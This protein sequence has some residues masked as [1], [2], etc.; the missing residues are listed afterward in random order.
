MF[1]IIMITCYNNMCVLQTVR[2]G[3]LPI[4]RGP[5]AGDRVQRTRLQ[6]IRFAGRRHVC[7]QTRRVHFPAHTGHRCRC[8]AEQASD[9]GSEDGQKKIEIV[10]DDRGSVTT[11]FNTSIILRYILHSA[12][13]IPAGRRGFQ[14]S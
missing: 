1:R 2:G 14:N 10:L 13:I 5:P 7:G 8:S 12:A 3:R 6:R 9:C 11:I 4:F